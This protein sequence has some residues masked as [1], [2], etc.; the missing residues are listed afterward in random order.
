MLPVSARETLRFTPPRYD[1]PSV[2]VELARAEAELLGIS[3]ESETAATERKLIE[4]RIDVLKSTA[5]MIERRI[6]E[7]GGQAPVYLLRVPTVSDRARVTR[8]MAAAGCVWPDDRTIATALRMAIRE[9]G[10]G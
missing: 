8:E 6:Q 4:D 5:A 3:D 10:A 1:L 7:A 2:E 9:S